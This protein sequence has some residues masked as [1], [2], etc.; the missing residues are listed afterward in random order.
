MEKPCLNLEEFWF[1]RQEIFNE[2]LTGK[3]EACFLGPETEVGDQTLLF[4]VNKH[5]GVYKMW[6]GKEALDL[7]APLQKNPPH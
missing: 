4:Q 5:C 2:A 7:E 3:W 6:S 1:Y